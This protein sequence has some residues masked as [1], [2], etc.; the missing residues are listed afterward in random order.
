METLFVLYFLQPM[1]IWTYF[2]MEQLRDWHIYTY[3]CMCAN[4]MTDRLV[5]NYNRSP[6]MFRIKFSTILFVILLLISGM[7]PTFLQHMIDIFVSVLLTPAPPRPSMTSVPI[8]TSR[9]FA[10]TLIWRIP[11]IN[12]IEEQFFQ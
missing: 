1:T 3:I 7:L 11:D 12:E 9:I 6:M 8:G 2:I 10:S 4:K 5:T